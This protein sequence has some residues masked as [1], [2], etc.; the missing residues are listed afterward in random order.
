MGNGRRRLEL[1]RIKRERYWQ[2]EFEAWEKSGQSQADYCRKKGINIATWQ[3]WKSQVWKKDCSRND[4]L[5]VRTEEKT[6][7]TNYSSAQG[8]AGKILCKIINSAGNQLEIYDHS[9][10]CWIG[11]LWKSNA[12]AAV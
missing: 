1:E 10:L 11:T 8:N 9:L 4:W 12:S 6:L 2:G 5:E 3:K 7:I